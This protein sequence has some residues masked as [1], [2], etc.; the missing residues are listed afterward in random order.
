VAKLTAP[1]TT[2]PTLP[3]APAAN[4]V[5]GLGTGGVPAYSFNVTAANTVAFRN[6]WRGQTRAV[7]IAW[8]GDSTKAGQT[9]SGGNTQGINSLPMRLAPALIA[10]GI[11]AGA[12]NSFGDKAAYGQTQTLANLV[13]ADARLSFS[14]GF[15][16][17]STPAAGGASYAVSAAGAITFTPQHAVNEARIMWRDNGTGR[18]FN[19]AVDGGATTQV[20]STGAANFGIT[21]IPLG[22][23][24]TH[25]ITMNWVAG[26]VQ[27]LAI[28]AYDNTAPEMRSWNWGISGV[29]S[30]VFLNNA[31]T[32]AGRLAMLNRLQPDLVPSEVGVI[33]DWRTSVAVATSKANAK[34]FAQAV[35]AYGGTPVLDVPVWDNGVV[36]NTANQQQYVD[37]MYEIAIEENVPLFDIRKRVGWRSFAEANAAGFMSDVVHPTAL[38]YDDQ[39]NAWADFIKAI[40]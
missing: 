12:G 34:A 17:G 29:P 13:A 39:A 20:N 28:E 6:L 3:L 31:D 18:N 30:S 26:A 38:G 33:N 11:K 32:G 1:L 16:V 14:G 35:K 23:L 2:R 27:I 15:V 7:S 25:T 36:G 40:V 8:N 21:T 22:S 4:A 24:G 10:R 9:L 5:L 37:A 19:W